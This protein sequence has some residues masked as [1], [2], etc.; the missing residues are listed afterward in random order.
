MPVLFPTIFFKQ[1]FTLLTILSYIPHHQ[2]KA[3]GLKFHI[4]FLEPI[5]CC[6]SSAVKL[7]PISL[8]IDIGF[9]LLVKNRVN[10]L[11]HADALSKGT[12]SKQIP[13][14]E[15]HVNKNISKLC[16][17]YFLRICFIR[18]RVLHNQ[19]MQS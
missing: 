16:M 3:G 11:M 5:R 12:N 10:P 14:V 15:E 6:A 8:K 7:E 18:T 19:Y 9:P 17:F 4:I 13:R 1:H 2:G